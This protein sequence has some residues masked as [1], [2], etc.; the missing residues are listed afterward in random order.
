ME[1][2]Q[3]GLYAKIHAV[4]DEVTFLAKD[5]EVKYE[6][7]G[8]GYKGVSE[9]KVLSTIR[10][11]LLKHKLVLIPLGVDQMETT[12]KI[13]TASFKWKLVDGETGE[14][15]VVGSIGS[16]MDGADKRAGKASTYALKIL[17]MK[18]FL[19]ISGE[20]TDNT[21][22]DELIAEQAAMDEALGR[23]NHAIDDLYADG[24][25]TD[26]LR[27]EAKAKAKTLSHLS[28]IEA[29]IVKIKG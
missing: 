18:M 12:G 7:A 19:L 20:D 28:E 27:I 14:F 3:T 29:A 5:L 15:E 17:L 6:G 4:M 13:L 1:A 10:P 26:E 23:L 25:M 24:K 8:K 2:I 11:A 16:G 9:T 21:H 22:S